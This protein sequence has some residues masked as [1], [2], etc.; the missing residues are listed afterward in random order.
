[1]NYIG[2]RF[3]APAAE[4]DAWSDALLAAGALS[5]DIS[6]PAA[7][8]PEETPQYGEP[9]EPGEHLWP[10]S[11]L[12]ALFA[13]DTDC[14]SRAARRRRCLAVR[15]PPHES[16]VIAEQDWV[17]AT[18]AQFGPVRIADDF[19]IVPS[20]AEPPD[21]DTLNVRLDPGLAFGTGSH[22]TTCLC[23][24]WMQQHLRRGESLLD[25][26]CGSGILAIAGALLGAGRV[27]G[28][29]V[30]PQAMRASEDNA[31]ANGVAATFVLPDALP[32]GHVR[33]GRREHPRQSADAARA[34]ARATRAARRPPCAF[35]HSRAAG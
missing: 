23:L 26:G 3:D 9:G 19:W 6:D 21:P 15:F 31:R 32:A 30:D 22:P 27:V 34:R 20:W 13:P 10:I 33:H 14:A 1:M 2:V 28:T 7:G 35:G 29:D 8:T 16:Y 5:V 11:R 4:A 24:E 25:Y 17:R 18:Q 12:A